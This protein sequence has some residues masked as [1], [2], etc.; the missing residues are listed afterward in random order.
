MNG[1][2]QANHYHAYLVRMWQSDDCAPWRASAQDVQ[3][4]QRLLFDSLESL[5]VFLHN[6]AC[7]EKKLDA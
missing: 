2:K 1:L 4:G 7:L 5:F 6:Q 3:T